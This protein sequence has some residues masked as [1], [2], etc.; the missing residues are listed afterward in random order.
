MDPKG[1]K[2]KWWKPNHERYHVCRNNGWW[3]GRRQFVK[4]Q[5]WWDGDKVAQRKK[6]WLLPNS[7]WT[8][9][10]KRESQNNLMQV[11]DMSATQQNILFNFSFSFLCIQSTY[12]L[13]WPSHLQITWY[14]KINKQIIVALDWV[15]GPMV[16]VVLL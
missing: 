16:S 9:N 8:P 10:T 3:R 14:K 4:L 2:W 15:S 6:I 1:P 7:K 12:S 11:D 5:W 13:M